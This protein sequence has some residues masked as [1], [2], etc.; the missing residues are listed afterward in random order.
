MKF[1]ESVLGLFSYVAISEPGYNWS[2]FFARDKGLQALKDLETFGQLAK[3][4]MPADLVKVKN[5]L[6]EQFPNLERNKVKGKFYGVVGPVT[7]S[8]EPGTKAV[9]H[10]AMLFEWQNKL[11]AIKQAMVEVFEAPMSQVLAPLFFVCD[12]LGAGRLSAEMRTMLGLS[13]PDSTSCLAA[14]GKPTAPNIPPK[15]NSIVAC[16]VACAEAKKA[17]FAKNEAAL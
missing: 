4:E 13:P 3:A 16:A 2:V 1:A 10:Q 14:D 12:Q 17:A 5:S 11:E 7:P 6:A 9:L 8:M 15:A